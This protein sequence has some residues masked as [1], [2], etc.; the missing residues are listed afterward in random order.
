MYSIIQQGIKIA[1]YTYNLPE[2][3]IAT[4]PALPKDSAQLLVYNNETITDDFFYNIDT[5]LPQSSL[6]ISNNSKVIP[7]RIIVPINDTASVEIFLLEPITPSDYLQN[8]NTTGANICIWKCFV[9]RAKKWKT[10]TISIDI[11][12]LKT[13][14]LFSKKETIGNAYVIQFEW[15][16]DVTFAEIIHAIGLIP[17]PPYIKRNVTSADAHTYQT[18]FAQHQGSVAAPTAGLHFTAQV[19]QQLQNK[20][21]AQHSVTLHVGAGTFLPVKSTTIGEHQMHSELIEVS[22]D[23]LFEINN[24]KHIIAVGT[25]SM[26]T[27]ETL[28]WIGV[29]LHHTNVEANYLFTITQWEI[30]NPTN[31]LKKEAIQLVID[32][33][34]KHNVQSI[35]ANAQILIAPGYKFKIVDQ[36][37]T[38][39]HQPNST[40]L[41][42]VAA[43]IGDAWQQVYEHALQKKY[44]FLSYGDACLFTKKSV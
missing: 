1:D 14:L 26:R 24:A 18:I 40:L 10:N 20:N 4:Q 38:N 8:L 35:K 43:F 39:F 19:L 13:T 9:G 29:Q 15:P 41:L 22:L 34:K 12:T 16:T 17:L 5:H 27:L 11:A 25:T 3:L 6:L 21:I 37:I 23:T 31:L 30:Y 2:A 42:L 33:C 7:A 44:R 36:L 32:Y 28:Y